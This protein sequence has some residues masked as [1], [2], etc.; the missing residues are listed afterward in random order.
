MPRVAALAIVERCDARVIGEL[1][2]DLGGGRFTKETLIQLEVGVDELAKPGEALG[3]S[4]ILGRV[5]A[6]N[7][8]EAAAGCARLQ[9]AF[10]IAGGPTPPPALDPGSRC[11]TGL[12]AACGHQAQST[13][14]FTPPKQ[15]DRTAGAARRRSGP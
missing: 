15:R 14:S 11:L 10:T 9:S 8:A 5:H 7:E 13:G 12:M 3:A 4:S 2:R 1:V 6:R